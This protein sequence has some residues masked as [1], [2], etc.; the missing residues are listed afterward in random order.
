MF[1][2][3]PGDHC[4]GRVWDDCN[5]QAQS[6]VDIDTKTVKLHA[7]ELNGTWSSNYD[8]DLQSVLIEND[9]R[10]GTFVEIY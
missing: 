6:P 4:W 9:G 5:K 10:T 2:T 3:T 7:G 8:Q 1:S